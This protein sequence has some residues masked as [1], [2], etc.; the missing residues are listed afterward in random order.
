MKTVFVLEKAGNWHTTIV[1]GVYST[2]DSARKAA[3]DDYDNEGTLNWRAPEVIEVSGL[4]SLES[5]GAEDQYTIQEYH[6]L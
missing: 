5:H 1:I 6:L 3:D 2:S 4:L